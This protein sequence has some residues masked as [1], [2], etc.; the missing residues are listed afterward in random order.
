[1][2]EKKTLCTSLKSAVENCQSHPLHS[3]TSNRNREIEVAVATAIIV[4]AGVVVV[5]ISYLYRV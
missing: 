5:F 2:A 1:M 4:A 3:S